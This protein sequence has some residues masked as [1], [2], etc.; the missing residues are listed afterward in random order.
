MAADKM[1]TVRLPESYYSLIAALYGYSNVEATLV[2][3]LDIALAFDRK[4]PRVGHKVRY[5][6]HPLKHYYSDY[7]GKVFT[8]CDISV[9]GFLE[10]SKKDQIIDSIQNFEILGEGLP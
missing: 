2:E 5:K 8:V 9:R 6:G 3:L 10:D 4:I 1:V 7:V